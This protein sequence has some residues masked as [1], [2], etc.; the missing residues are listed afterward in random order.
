MHS[1]TDKA[2]V[3]KFIKNVDGVIKALLSG[4]TKKLS[5]STCLIRKNED[6][7]LHG[8]QHQ[9]VHH[10]K[11]TK[12]KRRIKRDH[13]S[14]KL[15]PMS[16]GEIS[17]Q[18]QRLNNIREEIKKSHTVTSFEWI[19]ALNRKDRPKNVYVC[20]EHFIDDKPSDRNPSPK[21]KMGYENKTTPGRRKILKHQLS[22]KKR[23]LETGDS[24]SD[25][26]TTELDTTLKSE[27]GTS[28]PYEKLPEA[29]C[30]FNVIE[31][32]STF[33]THYLQ[34]DFLPQK[35]HTHG[36]EWTKFSQTNKVLTEEKGVQSKS[37]R[38]NVC[39]TNSSF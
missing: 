5:E 15:Q 21:L 4:Y 20:S 12:Q 23:K 25:M 28:T 34:S 2:K 38:A 32:S 16:W 14:K 27:P 33:S 17:S 9:I 26:E 8:G 29:S 36:K 3:A 30:S 18:I 10:S 19:K 39:C 31:A 37:D 1:L 24:D 13:H 35:D 6:D 7:N 22:V 11:P